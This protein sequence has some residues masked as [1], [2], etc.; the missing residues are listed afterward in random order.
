MRRN[1]IL[2]H[3]SMSIL[4]LLLCP[5]RGTGAV[6]R[7]DTNFDGALDVVDAANITKHLFRDEAVP[8]LDACDVDG[9]GNVRLTDCLELLKHMSSDGVSD[10]DPSEPDCTSPSAS[11]PTDD[12]AI[13]LTQTKISELLTSPDRLLIHFPQSSGYSMVIHE[14]T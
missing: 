14:S 5:A 10:M 8:C 4:L 13:T 7:G 6:M 3:G 9:D 12:P 11:L 1:T 2:T